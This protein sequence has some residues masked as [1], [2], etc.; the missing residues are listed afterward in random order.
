MVD[1]EEWFDIVNET[2]QVIGKA[3]RKDVHAKRLRHRAIHVFVFNEQGQ[4]FLQ[5]RSHLKDLCPGL[6]DS[7]CSGHVDSTETYDEAAPR[8]LSE[9]LGIRPQ[10][11]LTKWFYVEATDETAME[12]VW[13]YFL[14][15]EGPFELNPTEIETGK[16]YS[17]SELNQLIVHIPQDF[18]PAFLHLWNIASRM[19]KP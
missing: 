2:D 11:G 17:L 7:S 12:F 10:E 5:K 1:K 3:L 14:K 4:I 9:E 18:S 13:V 19:I 6:W 16:W 8:E 15:H